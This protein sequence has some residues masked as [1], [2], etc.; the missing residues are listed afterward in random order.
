VKELAPLLEDLELH[1][2]DLQKKQEINPMN[3]TAG[4]IIK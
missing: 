1:K 4:R 3:F 2:L